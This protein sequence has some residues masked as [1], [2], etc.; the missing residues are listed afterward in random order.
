MRDDVSLSRLDKDRTDGLLTEATKKTPVHGQNPI[1]FGEELQFWPEKEGTCPRFTH[2]AAMHTEL[3]AVNVQG[4]L[5]QWRWAD[6]E[7]FSVNDVSTV[8]P[9]FW[10]PL[11][12]GQ[13]NIVD[14]LFFIPFVI[15]LYEPP[16]NVHLFI[17][18]TFCQSYGCQHYIGFISVCS[19]EMSF[20]KQSLHSANI[21]YKS[22]MQTY[23]HTYL[24]LDLNLLVL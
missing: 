22:F 7:P 4:E 13:C 10:T 17:M 19:N 24:L 5:C 14:M 3:V 11:Y 16:S 12:S 15:V 20:Y 23:W 18:D 21:F 1:Y 6:Y 2:I 9:F 8:V